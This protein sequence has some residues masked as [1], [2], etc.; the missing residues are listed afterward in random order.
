MAKR[1][2]PSAAGHPSCSLQ[3]RCYARTARTAFG[4][5][6]PLPVCA[7]LPD[8]RIFALYLCAREVQQGGKDPRQ[9]DALLDLGDDILFDKIAATASDESN[10]AVQLIVTEH[11]CAA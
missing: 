4:Y 6:V 9:R 1:A 10:G 7:F 11:V 5:G 2:M 3:T 8:H